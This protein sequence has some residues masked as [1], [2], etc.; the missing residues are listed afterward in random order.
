MEAMA[1]VGTQRKKKKKKVKLLYHKGIQKS[2][3][4]APVFSTSARDWCSLAD[5]TAR[6]SQSA[7]LE[8]SEKVRIT[9]L[10]RE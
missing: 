2:G 4:T 3:C 5:Y 10:R 8:L 7:G 1:R 6:V 9:F